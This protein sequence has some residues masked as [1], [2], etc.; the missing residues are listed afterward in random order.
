[1]ALAGDAAA[2]EDHLAG[3]GASGLLVNLGR[4]PFASLAWDPAMTR[5]F[6]TVAE[7]EHALLLWRSELVRQAAER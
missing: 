5:H 7:S 1:M 2:L 6:V 4:E 3:L